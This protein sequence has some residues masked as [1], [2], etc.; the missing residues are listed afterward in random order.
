MRELYGEI[1]NMD[2]ITNKDIM[3]MYKLMVEFYDNMEYENF[4]ED[5]RN[6]DYCIILRNEIRE[7]KGFSTQ[8][9]I[10]LNVNNRVIHGVFSGDTIIHKE[11]WGNFELHKVFTKFFFDYGEKYREFYW[12][13]ISKG[14]KTYKMIPMFFKKAYPN[15]REDTP[16][17][18]QELIIAFGRSA[19]P[20]EFDHKD[21][22][23]KYNKIKDKLKEGIA[24]IDE[25]KLRDRDIEFFVQKNPTYKEGNDLV[26]ITSLK[27]ENLKPAAN[28]LFYS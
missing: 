13:L 24:D 21:G 16:K 20:N 12:F 8:K 28:R 19:Y 11:Y 9:I 6:K 10:R 18:I 7:I 25:K 15:Y 5:L 14:Y 4:I 26:C 3:S 22:V 2:T 17:E 1:I 23:I 27:R